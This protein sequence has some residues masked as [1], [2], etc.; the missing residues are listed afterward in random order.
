MAEVVEEEKSI[1]TINI[2]PLVDVSLVLLLIFMVTMP[3]SMVHSLNVKS[4]LLQKYGLSTP[5]ENIIV[6]LTTRG[7]FVLDEN[8][9]K[10][11][12][13]YAQ[14]GM[15]LSQMIQIS[16]TKNLLLHV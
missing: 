2:T 7:V 11:P 6:Y 12:I 8:G 3:F 10:Q 13:P 5:Q 1:N 4:Q 9:R 16:S 14:F 15:I